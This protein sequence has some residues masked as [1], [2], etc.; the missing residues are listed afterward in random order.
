MVD[1]VTADTVARMNLLARPAL[2]TTFVVL[3]ALVLAACAGRRNAAFEPVAWNVQSVRADA[4]RIGVAMRELPDREANYP[5]ARCLACRPLAAAS[6]SALTAHAAKLDGRDELH[7]LRADLVAL[8]R[9]RG[10]DA[11]DVPDALTDEIVAA[12]G[13][14]AALPDQVQALRERHRLGRLMVIEFESLG[15]QRPYAHYVPVSLPYAVVDGRAYML[16]L[17]T[18]RVQWMHRMRSM[19]TTEGDWDEPPDYP[20]LTNAY[21]QAIEAVKDR[22]K[23][24]V[25]R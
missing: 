14:V 16:D 9:K 4:T 13:D 2:R 1:D 19:L 17:G 23:H 21:Y 12:G 7:E 22:V 20:G 6:N 15:L 25:E 5:G 18:R 24:I 10:I 11:V 3:S 8:L